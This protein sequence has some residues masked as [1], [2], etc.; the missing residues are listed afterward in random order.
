MRG[1]GARR[2]VFARRRAARGRGRRLSYPR[3]RH[4]V[5]GAPPGTARTR[6]PRQVRVVVRGRVRARV[7]KPSTLNPEPETLNPKH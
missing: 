5:T 7:G 6:P 2:G 1:V 3:V 4:A